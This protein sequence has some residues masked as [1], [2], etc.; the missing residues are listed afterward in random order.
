M[1]NIRNT[2]LDRLNSMTKYPSIL[3]YHEL[4]ERGVL[5][6]AVLTPFPANTTLY[7]TEKVDGTNARIV[8][9][10]DNYAIVGSREDFLW[11]S[12]DLIGNPSMGIVEYFRPV[13][14]RLLA[15]TFRLQ[16]E[17]NADDAFPMLTIYGELYGK[18]IGAAAKNYTATGSIGFRVFDI[19]VQN[20][21]EE[22]LSWDRQKIS[23][24]RENGGQN[25]LDRDKVALIA[26]NAGFDTVPHHFEMNSNDL[27]T[28]LADTYEFLKRFERTTATIDRDPG[29]QGVGRAEGIVIRTKDRKTIAKL[30]F[31]DYERKR[32]PGKA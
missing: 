8:F 16:L 19:V 27:P 25:F 18:N 12:R 21:Y 3:T 4:G 11:E 9:T 17:F 15:D 32:K 22:V 5:N 26:H 20:N 13:V 31:E 6:D 7:G 24:W 2:D 14:A 29:R 1:F 10:P 30:R 23:L 28:S